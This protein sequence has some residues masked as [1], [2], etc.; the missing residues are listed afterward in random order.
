MDIGALRR[1]EMPR[2]NAAL[3]YLE[4]RRSMSL[5]VMGIRDGLR[6]VGVS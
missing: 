3:G 4:A 6:V 5:R 2:L 1:H